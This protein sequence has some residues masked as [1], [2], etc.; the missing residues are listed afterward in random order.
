MNRLHLILFG[1]FEPYFA[2]SH[3]ILSIQ[4]CKQSGAGKL[5][6]VCCVFLCASGLRN[7]TCPPHTADK[8]IIRRPWES[9]GGR[10]STTETRRMGVVL[11]GML[12]RTSG[13]LFAMAVVL[14]NM[15]VVLVNMQSCTITW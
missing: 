4:Q 10:A 11:F 2:T 8:G 7:G 5:R 15:G 6:D 9:P 14:V 1:M 3:R 13:R 12:N